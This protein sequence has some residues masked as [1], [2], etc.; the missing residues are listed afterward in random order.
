MGSNLGQE[1]K[2][3]QACT[4]QIESPCAGACMLWRP[5]SA[6]REACAPNPRACALQQQKKEL[7]I[8]VHGVKVTS[9]ARELRPPYPDWGLTDEGGVSI[10][11]TV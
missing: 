4:P 7:L 5:Y 11:H 9:K 1:T 8:S 10:F 2:I 6:M 3:P